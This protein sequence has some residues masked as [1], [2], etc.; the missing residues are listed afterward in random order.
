MSDPFI[1]ISTLLSGVLLGGMLA[2]TALGLSIVLGVMRL[3]NLAHGELLVVGAYAGLFLL[4]WTGI[5]PLLLLPLIGLGVG[6]GGYLVYIAFLRPIA[7]RGPEAPMMTTFG[8]AVIAQNLFVA[9]LS[10]DTRSIDRPYASMPLELGAISVPQVYIIGFA[11]SVV[12][13]LGVHFMIAHTRFGRDLRASTDDP[14]AAAI[15]GVNVGR[16]HALTFALGAAAAGIGG[17]LMGIAF[18]FTPTTGATYLLT[19]F[20]I[21]VLGGLGSV[22][23]TLVG[24]IAIGLI[25]SLGGLVFG[26]GYRDLAGFLMFLLVLALRPKGFLRERG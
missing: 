18:S 13:I 20:A 11:I 25:Q 2:L 16:V 26:D 14:R 10:A 8:L 9:F 21:I 4:M 5:D 12:V 23:G 19:D 24:G 3:V 7:H 15:I 1:V 6:A 17:T 22:A